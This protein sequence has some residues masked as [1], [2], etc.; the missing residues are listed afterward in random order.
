[1]ENVVP[2][3]NLPAFIEETVLQVRTGLAQARIAGT[4]V[5]MPEVIQFSVIVVKS[6]QPEL[7]AY[8]SV[9]IGTN[10]GGQSGST[11]TITNGTSVDTGV[12]I[13]IDTDS[14]VSNQ[15]STDTDTTTETGTNTDTDTTTETGTTT[16]TDTTTETGNSTD[17]DTT[18]ETG[19]NTDTD[20]G[21]TNDT[22]VGGTTTVY[23]GSG[24]SE[25]TQS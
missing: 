8:D 6:W 3:A 19:T 18:T 25:S 20:S 4:L 2:I 21:T 5:E 23:N 12:E 16:D 24:Q 17:T 15:N 11:T 22:S 13:G 7:L 1:M 14:S 10:T 9:D